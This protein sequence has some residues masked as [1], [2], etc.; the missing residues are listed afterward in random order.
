MARLAQ[1]A[2]AAA[3]GATSG[4]GPAAHLQET[5]SPRAWEPGLARRRPDDTGVSALLRAGMPKEA[6]RD[7]G[8]ESVKPAVHVAAAGP[9]KDGSSKDA[10]AGRG[11]IGGLKEN[12]EGL[13][14]RAA[15]LSTLARRRSRELRLAVER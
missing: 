3:A 12:I 4:P 6:A 5:A 9:E 2:A 10:P 14:E 7:S 1:K 13:G 11:L 15:A 8:S